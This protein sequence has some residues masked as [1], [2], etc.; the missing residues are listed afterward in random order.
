MWAARPDLLSFRGVSVAAA[1]APQ[2][3]CRNVLLFAEAW[4]REGG[5]AV[6]KI[7]CQKCG[8]E[9]EIGGCIYF[10]LQGPSLISVDTNLEVDDGDVVGEVQISCQRCGNTVSLGV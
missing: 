4:D 7:I 8:E 3:Y 10:G 9:C 1:G 6:F 2:N 5:I